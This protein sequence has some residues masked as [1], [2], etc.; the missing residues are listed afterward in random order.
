MGIEPMTYQISPVALPTELTSFLFTI[1]P[2]F[3]ANSYNSFICDK[4]PQKAYGIVS[5]GSFQ[6]K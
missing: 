5:T 4:Y 1:E 6:K 2:V 3:Y